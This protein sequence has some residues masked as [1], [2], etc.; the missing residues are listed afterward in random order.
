[1]IKVMLVDDEP[2]IRMAMKSLFNWK[3]NGFEIVS[4][5]SNGET[6]ILKIK[7]NIPDIIITD[8]KMPIKSGLELVEYV[9]SNYPQIKCVI[10]SSYDDFDYVKEA[11]LQGAVDYI[12]KSDLN[13][14]KFADAIDRIKNK[15]F[16][17]KVFK[18]AERKNDVEDKKRSNISLLRIEM[19]K[20]I[21]HGR[22]SKKGDIENICSNYNINLT[23]GRFRLCSIYID[24]FNMSETLLEEKDY[25]M[26]KIT[27]MD[28]LAEM[29]CFE[30]FFFNEGPS[31]YCMMM[32][33]GGKNEDLFNEKLLEFLNSIKTNIGRYLNLSITI[34][35]SNPA[36]RIE[37]IPAMYEQSIEAIGNRFYD[38]YGHIYH[39][40]VHS[41]NADSESEFRKFMKIDN[42]Q[43]IKEYLHKGEWT[44]IRTFFN[45][46]FDKIAKVRY[47]EH[48]VKK[49]I[50]NLLF[51]M[52]GEMIEKTLNSDDEMISNEDLYIRISKCGL[53][54]EINEIVENYIT[55]LEQYD[56][57]TNK[58]RYSSIVFDA[59]EYIRKNYEDENLSLISAAGEINTN[60]SYLSRLFHKETN[61]H[62]S[63]Y[64]THL[65]IKR[66]Q[67]YLLE[68]NCSIKE[69]A[70]KVGYPNPKYFIQIFK[71]VTGTTPNS[72]R[73]RG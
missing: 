37:D 4:E 54:S 48:H 15:Y 8:I 46:L 49:I 60:P 35:L 1:M 20:D 63:E 68:D 34:G 12:L 36:N 30:G 26:I 9:Q 55:E 24:S 57:L 65:R 58:K 18:T 33:M 66:A 3:E 62:F 70:E 44:K 72:F 28:L 71:K 43:K 29:F 39:Y 31:R 42:I 50:T 21:V 59:V 6:A 69:I 56:E 38:G 32:Y 23:N 64:L 16:S 53:L 11:L 47:E 67:K 14:E 19:L 51:L 2:L 7:D 45:D 27:I 17:D 13:S 10:L 5:A 41:S 73:N 61:M 25:E 52:Q 40:I 22:L